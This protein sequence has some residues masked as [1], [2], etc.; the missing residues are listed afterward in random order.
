MANGLL[1]AAVNVG[2]SPLCLG[3]TLLSAPEVSMK[4][5]LLATLAVGMTLA[6]SDD[7]P[8]SPDLVGPDLALVVPPTGRA[9]SAVAD[10]SQW[11]IRDPG[12]VRFADGLTIIQGQVAD[13]PVTGDIEGT[14]RVT[15]RNAVLGAGPEAGHITGTTEVLV[16]S[17]FGRTDLEGSFKGPFS[18]SLADILFGESA[19]IRT[20]SGDFQGLVMHGIARSS[21]PA[22][23]VTEEEGTI[24]GR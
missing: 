6:C 4:R 13:C 15:W 24:L 20:G 7:P 18:A 22:S 1:T 23:R 19:N 9:Y 14:V 16:E 12:T 10:C 5:F 17:F 11:V 3:D 8:T 21:A 2:L